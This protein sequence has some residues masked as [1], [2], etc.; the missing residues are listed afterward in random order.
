MFVQQ[1]ETECPVVLCMQ[2]DDQDDKVGISPRP[3]C[4]SFYFEF[5]QIQSSQRISRYVDQKTQIFQACVLMTKSCEVVQ[6]PSVRCEVVALIRDANLSVSEIGGIIR[7][8]WAHNVAMKLPISN[9][10]HMIVL[11]PAI[12]LFQRVSRYTSHGLHPMLPR[13][14]GM[15]GMLEGNGILVRQPDSSPK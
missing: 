13:Q 2:R 15:I 5:R 3:D 14:R 4:R 11:C 10:F 1:R 12:L 6:R 7:Y 9:N 8:R